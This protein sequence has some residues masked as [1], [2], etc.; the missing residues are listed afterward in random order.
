MSGDLFINEV[1]ILGPKTPFKR[2]SF[3]LTNKRKKNDNKQE[4]KT[5]REIMK[6][7]FLFFLVFG[8]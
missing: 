3:C 8:S 6:G 7:P 2:V 4:I 5:E 1:H